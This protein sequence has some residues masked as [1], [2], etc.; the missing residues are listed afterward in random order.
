MPLRDDLLTPIPGANPSGVNLRYDPVTDKVKEARREEMEAPQGAWK[1]TVKTANYAEVVKLASEAIAKRGKDLQLSVWL[2][3]AHV[4]REGFAVLPACFSFLR[5]LCDRFWDTLYPEIEDGDLEVRAAPLDWLGSKL[6]EPIRLLPLTA[7][8]L[9]W[10]RYKESR[11]VGY[12]SGAT[13]EDKRKARNQLINEGKISAEEFDQ[14]L[15]ETPKAF[16]EKQLTTVQEALESLEELISFLDEKFGEFS[17]SFTRVRSAL[18]E[19]A[20]VI[21]SFVAKKGGPTPEQV[22]PSSGI[23]QSAAPVASSPAP[24]AAPAAA[25]VAAAVPVSAAVSYAPSGSSSLEPSD[26]DEVARRLAAI[27]KFLRKRDVYDISA[28]LI[29]RGFRWGE[30]RYNGPQ[31]DATA[32]M[33]PDDQTRKDLANAFAASQWDKVLEMTEQAMELPCGRGWLDLQRYTVKA[34]EG[35]GQW[36]AFVADAVR[37]GVRGLIQDLPA[38]LQM[39]LRDGLPAAD[40]ETRDW[41]ESEV[42]AGVTINFAAPVAAQA[43]PPAAEPEPVRVEAPPIELAAKPPEVEDETLAEAEPGDIFDEA[44]KTAREGRTAEAMTTLNRQLTTERSGRGRFKRRV[45]IAHLLMATGRERVAQPILDEIAKEIESR[46][47]EE[48]EDGEAV[49]YPLALLLRCADS[50]Q[51]LKRRLYA[52]ICRLDPVRAMQITV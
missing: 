10:F 43:P 30:I 8:G 7:N 6:D 22:V 45:Q 24:V 36:F 35:K 28:Y 51:D 20:Q 23:P 49:A 5:E 38:L 40:A 16:C 26:F 25:P 12:E 42:L 29:L 33:A 21:K 48:W 2:V 1:T 18:E 39:A 11:T 47:L 9:S 13:T 50:D 3:D 41:I 32:L 34:L 52:S 27:A 31:V 44:L 14:A 17:P 37:T 4:R 46:R 15:D 19:N